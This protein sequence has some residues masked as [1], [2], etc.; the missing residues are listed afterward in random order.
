MIRKTN[1][2]VFKDILEREILTTVFVSFDTFLLLMFTSNKVSAAGAQTER[3]KLWEKELKKKR[4]KYF[5][6]HP[7]CIKGSRKRGLFLYKQAL[8]L[9]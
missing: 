3:P 5:S 1:E 7:K 8:Y 9:A 4:S 2:V 6:S